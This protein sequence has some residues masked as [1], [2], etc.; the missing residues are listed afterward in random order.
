MSMLES[1]ARSTQSRQRLAGY[2]ISIGSLAFVINAFSWWS[3]ADFFEATTDN[4]RIAALEAAR[5]EF[6]ISS[7]IFGLAAALVGIGLWQLTGSLRA[8]LEIGSWGAIA[9]LAGVFGLLTGVF[10]LFVGVFNVVASPEAI[11]DAPTWSFAIYLFSMVLAMT[12]VALCLLRIGHMRW[13]AWVLIVGAAL[14]LG[15]Y[16]ITGDVVPLTMYVFIL[17]AGIALIRR[18]VHQEPSLAK[19]G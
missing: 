9:I 12:G 8:R 4:E 19:T 2:L 18:P 7:L 3:L 6:A 14:H 1:P 11:V 10:Y 15:Q 13:A 16:V 17:P 5:T